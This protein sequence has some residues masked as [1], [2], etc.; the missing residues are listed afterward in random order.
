MKIYSHLESTTLTNQYLVINEETREGIMIDVPAIDSWMIRHIEERKIDLRAILLTHTHENHSGGLGTI[1][2]IYNPEVYSYIPRIGGM[3][4]HQV[5]DGE[6]LTIA[7]LEVKGIHVPGHS[8]D[9][10][11]W[12]IGKALFTGDTLLS[13]EVGGTQGLIEKEVLIRGINTK[14]MSLDDNTLV[15]PGHGPLTK[16]RIERYFNQDLLEGDLFYHS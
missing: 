10:M 2:K 7:G 1:F 9:S 15:Y 13:G 4:V 6:T 12:K 5:M 16:I 3:Y 8:L 11:C 14:L